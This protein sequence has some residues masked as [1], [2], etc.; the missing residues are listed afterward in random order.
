MMR[1]TI[2]NT[3]TGTGRTIPMLRV[4]VRIENNESDTIKILGYS[5]KIYLSN[6]LVGD[7]F[8][9][10]DI[11]LSP[12]GE[13]IFTEDFKI[14]PYLFN[15]IEKERNFGDVVVDA[16]ARCL[17]IK[18]VRS[19]KELNAESL[20][21]NHVN[22]QQIKL[23]QSDWA[24]IV[25][26]LG[27]KNYQIFEISYSK[28]PS[29]SD[30]EKIM[31]RLDEA[32]DHFNQGRNEEVV[33]SC[34]KAFELLIPLVTT[35][36]LNKFEMNSELSKKIDLGCSDSS[37]NKK[38]NLIEE[39]R[40]KIWPILHIGPHEGYNVTREDAEFIITLSLSTIRYYAMRL[41][42]LSES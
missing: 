4:Q 22:I 28:V 38:S 23:S 26:D 33:T 12:K 37:P 10:E 27:Y 36:N 13:N 1:G 11:I 29:I 14:T 3:I 30:F 5:L 35:R 24:K 40:Q 6:L 18:R 8:N 31:K 9:L 34:R 41:N 20:E 39:L 25:S 19:A 32:Q 42:K 15:S 21:I 17:I 7:V 16:R 2:L